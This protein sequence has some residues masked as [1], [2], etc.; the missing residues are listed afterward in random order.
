MQIAILAGGLATR[1]R[2]ISTTKPKSMV[3][4]QGRPFLEYQ[5][6]FLK[7]NGIKD[8]LLCV[9][10][11]NEQIESYFGDGGQFGVSIRYSKEE[12]PLLGTAGALRNAIDFLDDTFFVMYGHSYLF[13]DL[14]QIRRYFFQ[15]EKSGLMVIYKNDNRYD[16]SN[17]S[18]NGNIAKNYSKTEQAPDMVYIDYGI[19][20]LR[21]KVLYSV[22]KND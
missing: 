1:L 13:L 4:I 6:E 8:I 16:I 22:P 5:L 20:L 21:K 19:S 3:T 17:V 7:N 11:L 9:G 12:G 14:K 18:I 10:H 15:F 2:P